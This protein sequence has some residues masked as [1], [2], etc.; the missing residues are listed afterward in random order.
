MHRLF[1]VIALSA[2]LVIPVALSAQDRDHPDRRQDDQQS[3]R[4]EDKGH[5]DFHEWNAGE[6]GAYRKYLKEHH[7]SYNDFG[8]AKKKDQ[9]NYWNWRHSHPDNDQR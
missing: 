5:K 1:K 4:Y 7:K 6:D 8:K 3:R 2:V 9:D